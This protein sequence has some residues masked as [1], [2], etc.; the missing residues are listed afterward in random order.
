M[1]GRASGSQIQDVSVI[2]SSV[3][4]SGTDCGGFI[5]EGKNVTIS[6]VYSDADMTVNTYTD[7]KN[8]TQS[9]GFI[10]NLTGKSSV[11]YVFAAGKVDNKTSEQLI[12]SSVRRT[13]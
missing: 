4:L 8:R 1:A 11:E 3:A 6:R 10:G 5:G 13:R 9:A 2:G 12:T 7:D